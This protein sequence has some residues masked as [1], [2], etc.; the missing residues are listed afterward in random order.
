M[1]ILLYRHAPTKGNRERRYIGWTDEDILPVTLQG[2]DAVTRVYTSA[3]RRTQQTA[4]LLFPRADIVPCE[5]LNEMHFGAF[6]GKNYI[7]MEDDTAYRAWVDAGCEPPCPG[8]EG[9]A[10]F[11]QRVCEAFESIVAQNLEQDTLHFVV[12]GGAIRALLSVYAVPH[13]D[14]FDVRTP[15]LGCQV[16]EYDPETRRMTRKEE[17]T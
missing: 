7:E 9:K 1:K 17:R 15:H 3:L 8:G 13:V 2:D 6:E 10:G 11:T 4:R 12:H 5:G 16:V 14:Y